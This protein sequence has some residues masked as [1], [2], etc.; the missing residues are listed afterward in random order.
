ML[1]LKYSDE[2]FGRPIDRCRDRS[3]LVTD[4]L[5]LELI[6]VNT[7]FDDCARQRKEGRDLNW[8][9]RHP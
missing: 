6:Q 4:L 3:E 8:A 1:S 7:V 2:E 5:V 9:I